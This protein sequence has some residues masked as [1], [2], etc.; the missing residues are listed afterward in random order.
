MRTIKLMPEYMAFPV[1]E[2]FDD[3][4]ADIDP[5][6][7]PL[8]PGLKKDLMD[9]AEEYEATY[10]DDHPGNSG[11]GTPEDQMGFDRRGR[12]LWQRLAD[13]LRGVANVSYYSI[14]DERLHPPS[15]P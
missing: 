11:F 5:A 14:A 6:E 3:G 2:D 7:L 1:W 10:D 15:T 4:T 9:W 13:Q 8:S 12:E